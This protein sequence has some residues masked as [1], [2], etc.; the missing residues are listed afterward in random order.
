MVTCTEEAT[1]AYLVAKPPAPSRGCDSSL[2]TASPNRPEE[3]GTVLLTMVV[4]LGVVM[5]TCLVVAAVIPRFDRRAPIREP[6]ARSPAE[7]RAGP[8]GRA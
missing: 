4:L 8:P 1:D 6:Q 7:A 5:V 3:E 2:W